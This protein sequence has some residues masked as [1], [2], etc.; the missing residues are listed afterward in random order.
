[1]HLCVIVISSASN[2]VN[3]LQIGWCVEMRGNYLLLECMQPVRA[4]SRTGI[5][6]VFGLFLLQIIVDYHKV[7]FCNPLKISLSPTDS[8]FSFLRKSCEKKNIRT[9]NPPLQK[10]N[11]RNILTQSV[12]IMHNKYMLNYKYGSE[13]SK[14]FRSLTYIAQWPKFDYIKLYITISS[15]AAYI[16]NMTLNTR[17]QQPSSSHCVHITSQDPKANS[18]DAR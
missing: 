18:Q 9:P 3:H 7:L 15:A 17:K 11:T 2:L 10:P 13:K 5:N 16:P 14:N 4:W 1:M 12:I 6:L 8:K